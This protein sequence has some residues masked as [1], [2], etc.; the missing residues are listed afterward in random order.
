GCCASRDSARQWVERAISASHGGVRIYN[1]GAASAGVRR[2]LASAGVRPV[3][4]AHEA[5]QEH[6]ADMKEQF[7]TLVIDQDAEAQA[8]ACL[9]NLLAVNDDP[10][11]LLITQPRFQLVT[12][13]NLPPE[14]GF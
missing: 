7:L 10:H 9:Q 14:L 8:L 11:N 6:A 3:W 1:T 13:E 5:T 12:L 2:A 4:I